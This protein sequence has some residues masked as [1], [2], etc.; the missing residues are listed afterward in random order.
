MA[1]IRFEFGSQSVV[2]RVFRVLFYS[3]DG[4]ISYKS[5]DTLYR[6]IS[7]AGDPRDSIVPVLDQWIKEGKTFTRD[8][9]QRIIKR[10]RHYRR[11]KHALEISQWMTDQRYFD[12]SAGDA[13]IRLDLITKV[14]GLGEAE[15]YFDYIPTQL[16]VF[17]TY[18]ALLNCY[19]HEKSVDK[20]E[21][22]FQKMK[23][24]GFAKTVLTYNVMLNLYSQMGQHEKLDPL[25]QE[26]EDRGI[27]HDKFTLSI[28]M[29]AYSA[30]A[31]VDGMEK[32]LTRME[33]DPSI[34]VD[35][36][37]YFLMA[38]GYMKAGLTDKALTMLKKSEALITGRQRRVA[39]D[40][41]LTMYAGIGKKDELYRIWNT[42]KAS[43]KI[44]NSTY[45]CMLSSLVKLDD[46]E[47]AEKIF[48]EWE[49]GGTSYD[50]RVPNRLISAYCKK[51]LLEKAEAIISKAIEKGKKP[52]SSTW[53]LLA[54]GYYENNQILNAV[55]TLKKAIMASRP[56]WRPNHATLAGCLEY[57]KE[58]RDVEGA[59]KLIRLLGN[60]GHFSTDVCDRLLNYI[61]N[62]NPDMNILDQIGEDAFGD[63][64]GRQ[65][66]MNPRVECCS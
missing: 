48:G 51:G 64:E 59:R 24:L 11:Y 62:G 17:Q 27:G 22:L 19:T 66:V 13:A 9:L 35:W 6:R 58:Q 18:G 28:R 57:Y 21:A 45:I 46:I 53:D 37:A 41:L 20:A 1:L 31:D 8:Y 3:T 39:V 44:Y 47:G 49:L 5:N 10:L 54:S 14:H 32:I 25:M 12:L 55:E 7:P 43:E 30:A 65:G 33:A 23:E 42:Y 60:S 61:E 29:S 2:S 34:I 4:I 63:D 40:Y 26:M 56:G 52:L 15:K 16:R 38:N 36:N 50:F